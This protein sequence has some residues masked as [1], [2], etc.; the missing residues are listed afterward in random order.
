MRDKE[1][2]QIQAIDNENRD[3]F[4]L[5]GPTGCGKSTAA[6]YIEDAH[7][8]TVTTFEMSDYVRTLYEEQQVGDVND[9]ELGA[10]AAAQKATYGD[11]YFARKLAKTVNN[12]NA[13]HI[14][15]SGVRSPEEARAIKDVFGHVT[16][17]AI[18]TLPDIRFKRK[19][20]AEPSES[21]PKWNEFTE[22]NEREIW[23]WGCVEFYAAESMY[24]AD[25]IIPNSDTLDSLQRRIQSMVQHGLWN[26][27]PFVEDKIEAV[28]PY[29]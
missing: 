17:V 23:T 20:G 26:Q 7:D 11:G 12:P 4:A 5:I 2:E 3:V 18:W 1:A 6:E 19:Y 21:H 13:P 27:N 28:A 8:E 9:N 16:S 24:E 25:H 14:I 10:W 15:I 29:L 22:R